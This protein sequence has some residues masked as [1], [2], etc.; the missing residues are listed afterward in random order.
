MRTAKKRAIVFW[1]VIIGNGFLYILKPIILPGRHLM[2][3]LYIIPGKFNLYICGKFTVPKVNLVIN[4]TFFAGLEP[5]F[6]TPN[7]HIA[8]VL[9]AMGVCVSVYFPSNATAL[10]IV[11]SGYIEAQMLAWSAEFVN[12]WEDA[13]K[14]YANYRRIPAINTNSNLKGFSNEKDIV[15]N[16]YVNQRLRDIIKAHAIN[17]SLF[18]EMEK[19]FKGAIAVEFSLLM[20]GLIAELLAGLQNTYMEVPF[21]LMQVGMD[22]F[23]GQ[24]VIDASIEFERAVYHCKWENF[25][26]D[27]MKLVLMVVMTSQ[28]T[29]TLSAGGITKL[30]F[31]S[32]LAIIKMIY[33]AYTTLS[34]TMN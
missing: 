20:V 23:I 19:A 33:S 24:K 13:D 22:C 15:V 18:S 12:L 29:M 6:E 5:M 11:I 32:L 21:A 3:D 26:T 1:C 10:Q 30:N 27:N 14:Y 25:N 9:M 2:E 34:A 31:V 8:F 7:Y 16:K 17:L 4:I 28:R